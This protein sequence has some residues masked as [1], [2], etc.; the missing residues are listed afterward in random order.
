MADTQ[1]Q[2]HGRENTVTFRTLG[3][4]ATAGAALWISV[5]V[6]DVVE[7]ASATVRIAM[8]P[9]LAQLAGSVALALLIGVVFEW[10]D[11]GGASSADAVL[12]LYGLSALL[13][14]YL[15][16]L[17]DVLPVLR[18]FAGPG[19]YLVWLIV[20][21]QV[22]WA[23]LGS[24]SG[25]R[26][27]ATFHDLPSARALFIIFAAAATLLV[28]ASRLI[29]PSR[30]LADTDAPHYL[31]ATQSLIRDGD[32]NVDN[33]YRQHAY[34]AYS[35]NDVEARAT[36]SGRTLM[37]I[38]LPLILAPAF[39]VAGYTGS[40]TWLALL[41]A[42]AAALAW[43][44]ARRVTESVSAATF[45]A[46][47]T[48]LSVPA[49]VASAT[50]APD[51][52]AAV[53]LVLA[54]SCALWHTPLPVASGVDHAPA[55]GPWRGLLLGLTAGGLP[56]L[57]PSYAPAALV[58][59]ALGVARCWPWSRTGG[60]RRV[61]TGLM[62]AV[63]PALVSLAFWLLTNRAATGAW[64]LTPASWG[65]PPTPPGFN[66]VGRHAFAL[67]V[68]QRYGAFSYAPTFAI[69]LI[70]L[71]ALWRDTSQT[72]RWAV[73]LSLLLAAI[74]VPAAVVVAWRGTAL[75]PGELILPALLLATMPIAWEYRRA[76]R[77]PERR[78]IYRLM[79][80]MGLGASAAVVAV[81]GGALA[82][83]RPDGVSRLA[84]WLAPDWHLWLY[85]PDLVAQSAWL[86]L[87][88]TVI[89]LGAVVVGVALA[90][91]LAARAGQRAP[92][93]TGRGLA[94]VR[95]DAGAM[96]ALLLATGSMPLLIGSWLKPLPDA[97]NRRHIEMLDSFDP[98]A[99]PIALRMDPLSVIE[100]RTVPGLFTLTARPAG[101][102]PDAQGAV[103]FNANF[104]LPAGRYRVQ[105]VGRATSS[106]EGPLSGRLSLQAG[107]WGGSMVEWGIEGTD[108]RQWTDAFDLPADMG[109][110]RFATSGK[111]GQQVRE[112]RLVPYRVVP[113]LDRIAAEDVRAAAPFDRLLF[114]FHDEEA[115]P[116]ATGFWVRGGSQSRVSVVSR[117]G[118][119]ISDVRLV[120][121]SRVPNTIHLEMPDRVWTEE[122]A[123]DQER[124]ILIK[125][126]LL[127]GTVRL[128]I[129][130]ER[131]FYPADTDPGS[132]D[133]R[134]LGCYVRIL[135]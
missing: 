60:S 73:E 13:L 110:I 11:A 95:A 48:T 18:V 119:L 101:P 113:F 61:A 94:F 38:G 1:V 122:L 25:R 91:W 96:V 40:A 87:V 50:I 98:R 24:G 130:P 80:L 135:E 133:R 37:P 81:D 116:D 55:L 47:A 108:S 70:G 128:R 2:E 99:R 111:L 44:W 19:R 74:V 21:A 120:L 97:R 56:W 57:H 84:E 49:V 59:I 132:T 125:P 79:L 14:P 129:T 77:Q 103:E 15:P 83:L 121:R 72:R 82:A 29:A 104:A 86:G 4:W 69:A 33:N 78:A 10:R 134:H 43:F 109:Q 34:A 31:V 68:D 53:L 5:G 115:Y 35:D 46:A 124:A 93:R 112:L 42:L 58:L 123:A 23:A 75:R 6:L 39:W 17:P 127:D 105:V 54:G 118:L 8:L 28:G 106:T 126:T 92:S 20:I 100:A 7:G 27:A 66:L 88:Q 102:A 51:V 65:G 41:A 32:L 114:L 89:W 90:N 62:L 36:S 76:G 16:W 63:T 67:L 3:A 117:S 131:G 107:T 22:V 30:L 85:A 71:W 64:W 52:P 26:V 45:A 12:P 9:G